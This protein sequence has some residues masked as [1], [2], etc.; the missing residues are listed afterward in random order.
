VTEIDSAGVQLLMS[1]RKTAL[2]SQ[3][4]VHLVD[5]SAAVLE[6]FAT[7]GLDKHFNEHPGSPA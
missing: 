6:V 7:L 1:A 2:A 5:P 4:R 3:R